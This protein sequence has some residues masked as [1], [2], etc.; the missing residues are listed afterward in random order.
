MAKLI[1]LTLPLIGAG[2]GF[3]A[4]RRNTKREAIYGHGHQCL[5][6]AGMLALFDATMLFF[7]F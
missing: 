5:I 3:W 1:I 6:A 4:G 7:W 2:F